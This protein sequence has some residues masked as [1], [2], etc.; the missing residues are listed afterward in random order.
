MVGYEKSYLY[1]IIIG[2]G[3]IVNNR[4][5][6]VF[7]FNKWG[8]YKKNP[9]KAGEISKDLINYLKPKFKAIFKVE[10]TFE[11]SKRSWIIFFN[12]Y[13]SI[14]KNLKSYGIDLV[15]RFKDN[16]RIIN[17][18]NSMNKQEKMHF[19]AG[20]ADVVGSVN[21]QHRSF[22]DNKQ[23]ISLEISGFNYD[24]IKE[25][26]CIFHDLEFP[27]DQIL[28]N[29]P[30]MH[31]GDNPMY[32]KWNKGNKI[33]VLASEFIDQLTF[34]FNSKTESAEE[35]IKSLADEEMILPS[36]CPNKFEEQFRVK[37][38]AVHL[39]EMSEKLPVKIRGS[40]YIH[41]GHICCALDCPHAPKDVIKREIQSENIGHI[42]SYFPINLN[43]PESQVNNYISGS[44]LKDETYIARDYKFITLKNLFENEEYLHLDENETNYSL[45]KVIK[46]L[47]F[48]IQRKYKIL[49]NSQ[50]RI[51][52]KIPD[53]LLDSSKYY[54]EII[55]IKIP[56]HK[57]P[58]I[59]VLDNNAALVGPYLKH[60]YRSFTEFDP[61]SFHLNF[62]GL[63]LEDFRIKSK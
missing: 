17:M 4:L 60:L 27:V 16:V 50:T 38:K 48:L 15:G 20:L 3:K 42:F 47:I 44:I 46:G 7:P 18:V 40:H 58:I 29:H 8:N 36:L 21:P 57:T 23:I 45:K 59:L 11:V 53:F 12:N 14:I 34:G 49:T 10:F 2:G 31:A 30:N 35:N 63:S 19:I 52:G 25:I 28:W 6:I 43:G 1:G 55:T 5:E 24:L 33:R 9:S 41:M 56:A 32:E 51:K 37:Q 61:Q 22:K 54:E 39:S 13:V 26:C 62:R